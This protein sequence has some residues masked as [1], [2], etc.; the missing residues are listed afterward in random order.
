MFITLTLK[1]AEGQADIRIDSEQKI[2]VALDVLRESGKLPPGEIPH[3]YRSKL[4]ETVV[5]AYKTFQS[6]AIF[7]G[8]ILVA[9]T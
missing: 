4:G 5:S 3:F 7:D 8:D 9:I 6:E 1:T 2:D